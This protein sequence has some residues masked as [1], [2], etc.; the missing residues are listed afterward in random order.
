VYAWPTGAAPIDG[1]RVLV[2]AALVRTTG[3]CPFCFEQ[4][5]VRGAVVSVG[6]T[7]DVNFAGW[8]PTWAPWDG[9]VAWGTGLARADGRFVMYGL[10]TTGLARE[11]YVATASRTDALAG[12][13][14]PAGRPVAAGVD[15]GGVTAYGTAAGWHV[16]TVR[17]SQ[18]VRLD[19][20]GP[21][22]PFT[23]TTIGTVPASDGHGV[24]YAA[25]AHPE[26]RMVSGGLLI[27]VCRN[28]LDGRP[29]PLQQYQPL[30]L[31]G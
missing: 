14:Q 11:L 23:E 25:A 24:Y 27:T 19:S 16:L 29:R 6:P 21:T 31:T 12:R 5:G 3:T 10:S 28:W 2:S 9:S 7:G 17:G 26:F 4:V 30:F 1:N 20:P 18:L 13:W 22:G 8:T 15:P